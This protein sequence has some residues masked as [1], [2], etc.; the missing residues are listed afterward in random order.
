MFGHP[1]VMAVYVGTEGE[2]KEPAST[3]C[4]MHMDICY[5]PGYSV[6]TWHFWVR[7][8]FTPWHMQPKYESF[9]FISFH[10]P[11]EILPQ[12]PFQIFFFFLHKLAL[13]FNATITCV[14]N[15]NKAKI[16]FGLPMKHGSP[17]TSYLCQDHQK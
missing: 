12:L 16:S 14:V 9:F 11:N 5:E 7:A 13:I 17:G 15:Y 10:F 1:V 3:I 6:H 2:D 8:L 4:P